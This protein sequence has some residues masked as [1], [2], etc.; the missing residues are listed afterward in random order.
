[1]SDGLLV[2]EMINDSFKKLGKKSVAEVLEEHGKKEEPGIITSHHRIA[3]Q[4]LINIY[5]KS[6]GID[7]NEEIKSTENRKQVLGIL[8]KTEIKYID[9]LLTEFQIGKEQSNE[10][11]V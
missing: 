8:S 2:Q 9:N 1:M 5:T 10:K 3:L 4:Q 11:V 6:R 7:L